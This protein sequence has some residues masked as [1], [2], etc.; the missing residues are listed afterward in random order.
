MI[1]WSERN[2]ISLATAWVKTLTD[3]H[4]IAAVAP[5]HVILN[6]TSTN[7]LKKLTYKNSKMFTN[8]T[9]SHGC[10]SCI[11]AVTN[12]LYCMFFWQFWHHLQ[13][14]ILTILINFD[15]LPLPMPPNTQTH[16]REN[17][18]N[19][20]AKATPLHKTY[21]TL[22]LIISNF[23]CKCASISIRKFG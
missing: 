8:T 16:L 5:I 12:I 15:P 14:F 21:M 22:I 17:C 13:P 7:P 20:Q 4:I 6:N 2:N 19:Y 10:Q 9:K 3:L 1:V 11:F 23:T 18:F